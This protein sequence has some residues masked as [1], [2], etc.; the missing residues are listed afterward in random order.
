MFASLDILH[1][2]KYLL[3]VDHQLLEIGGLLLVWP[4]SPTLLRDMHGALLLTSVTFEHRTS[5]NK[6]KLKPVEEVQ[7]P[8]KIAMKIAMSAI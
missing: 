2:Q 1:A 4:D 8:V 6:Q 3:P 5:A 7:S